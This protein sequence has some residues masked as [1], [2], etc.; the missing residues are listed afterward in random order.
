LG[1]VVT[2]FHHACLAKTTPITVQTP[3]PLERENEDLKMLPPPLSLYIHTPWCVQKCPYCDFNSH[4]APNGAPETE[5]IAALLR[6]L[7]QDLP[8]IWGRAISTV[9]IGGGTPSLFSPASI[10]A[11]LQG[12]R[13]RLRLLPNAEITLEA[14][15]GTVDIARFEGYRRAGVNRLSIGIQSFDDAMLRRIGRIHGG[16]EAIKAAQAARLAGFDNFNL[17]LMFGLPG[18]TLEAALRDLETAIALQP[19]HLSWYQLTLEPHTEFARSP[20]PALPDDDA[21]WEIQQAGQALLA[22]G[23]YGQYE[24]SAYARAGA[25]CRHNRNYWEFGDYLGIGAGAHGKLSGADGI[26]RYAKPRHPREYLRCYGE[27]TPADSV[28]ADGEPLR[29]ADAALEFM[30]NAL[31]LRHGFDET[32]FSARTGLPLDSIAQ[33]LRQARSRGWLLMENQRITPT[34]LGLQYLNEL[35]ELFVP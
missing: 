16:A 28:E 20:P 10:D 29:A 14:N 15:P 11:L 12:V 22:G 18:Q 24:I 27:T 9:F 32:L 2:I 31:R 30:L 17:D 13:A 8:R 6:D 19:P 34:P 4:A 35:L 25:Q 26:R 23:G 3:A 1:E 7:E 33:P 21:L 5:Y